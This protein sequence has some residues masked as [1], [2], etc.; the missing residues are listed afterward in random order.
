M[1]TVKQYIKD[2]ITS[3]DSTLDVSDSS[4]LTDLLINPAASILDPLIAQ[5]NHL[6]DNLGIHDPENM[7]D[8]ELD[9]VAANFL[10]TRDLGTKSTGYVELLYTTPQGIFIPAQTQFTTGDGTIFITTKDLYI[11]QGTMESNLWNFPYYSSGPIPVESELVGESTALEPNTI[12]ATTLEPSPARVTNPAA[13]AGGTDGETNL[14]FAARIITDVV[15]NSL[16]SA[17]SISTSLRKTFPTIQS[18]EVTGME[19]DEMLR[20][21]VT[22]G[23]STYDEITRINYY[24]KV[25]GLNDPPYPGS[26]AY[27]S[28]FYDDPVTS[29]ILADL[30]NPE[31]FKQEF[32]TEQYSGLYKLDD[33]YKTT[34][35]TTTILSDNFEAPNFD[36][37]WRLG[38]ASVSV[39]ST[40]SANEIRIVSYNNS[41]QVQFG[42]TIAAANRDSEIRL[43]GR[44]IFAMINDLKR[45]SNYGPSSSADIPWGE[46]GLQN[47]D[48][49]V[50]AVNTNL[51][52]PASSTGTELMKRY[53]A[54]V[55]NQFLTLYNAAYSTDYYPL[56]T[57]PL[58]FHSGITITGKFTTNDTNG[59]L[60]YVTVLRD[61]T[62]K[63]PANG[64]GFAWMKG[65]GSKYNV[66]LVDNSPLSNDLFITENFIVQAN[67]ENTW[68]AAAKAA[69]VAGTQYNFTLTID[70]YYAMTLKIGQATTNDILPNLYVGGVTAS[71]LS[72]P[73]AGIDGTHFGIGVLGTENCLWWYDDI[74]IKKD[75]GIHTAVLF[76]FKVLPD[77]LPNGTNVTVDYYG[78]GY[79]GTSQ[80][81][82]SLFQYSKESGTWDW[83]AV[84]TNTSTNATPKAATKITK[85]FDLGTNFRNDSNEVQFLA[86]STYAN[87]AVTE[88]TTYFT[89]LYETTS[90]GVHT[91][92]CADIYINDTSKILL[93]ETIIVGDSIVALSEA[94]G[95]YIPLHSI[96]AVQLNI[97]DEVLVENVDW[98]LESTSIS[99]AFSVN[100]LPYLTFSNAYIGSSIRVIYRYYQNGEAIQTLL[101]SKGYRYSGTS[102]L[103]KIMPPVLITID[104]L[105]FRGKASV[106]DVRDAIKEYV[107]KLTSTKIILDD[108][109]NAVY[110]TGVSWIDIANLDI[111]IQEYDYKR[112]KQDVTALTTSYT[113][114]A[115][116]AYF[117]DDIS[118]AGVIKE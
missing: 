67:G 40:L 96:I 3:I 114:G 42:D 59:K 50:A 39:S 95:F 81:G 66:Y 116:S 76:K 84:G 26:R 63:D 72:E 107:N 97:T 90:S 29:G 80:Y 28:V 104:N 5:I 24:G 43:T 82:L 87:T 74:E 112:I 51:L 89:E 46:P 33:V 16:A 58:D 31:L 62:S 106:K 11:D 20:D 115:L 18:L 102:N 111:N 9:A 55:V 93:A 71:G 68:K 85:A 41:R 100:E 99:S 91:G 25:S 2:A 48:E 22:S 65:D 44:K 27:V 64:F 56:L 118:L 110:A 35:A 69:I 17:D 105:K 45:V 10:I 8:D 113:R 61:G 23:I 109:L 38:D 101:D 108:I 103:A 75:V 86:T 53:Y 1:T 21:L 54:M 60:S 57:A 79:D 13:F 32:I 15:S 52:I 117:C 83:V 36:G 12:V 19:D 73:A 47:Y 70:P 4:S 7:S 98:S 34:L 77:V 49:L 94:N 78:Y 92:G 30:P 6:Q 14:E 37:K 88:V